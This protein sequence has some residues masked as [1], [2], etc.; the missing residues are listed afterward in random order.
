MQQVSGLL[1]ALVFIVFLSFILAVGL[2][3][4]ISYS[5]FYFKYKSWKYYKRCFLFTLLGGCVGVFITYVLIPKSIN[6]VIPYSILFVTMI[7]GGLGAV[8]GKKID[9]TKQPK[10]T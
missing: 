2:I 10:I 4:L 8:W 9:D 3:S 7:A 5:Y 6:P 1:V